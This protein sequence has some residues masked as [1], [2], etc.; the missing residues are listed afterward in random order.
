MIAAVY[1]VA[2][3]VALT[4]GQLYLHQVVHGVQPFSVPLHVVVALFEAINLLIAIW[5]IGLGLHQKQINAVHDGYR[6]KFKAGVIPPV[7]LFSSIPLSKALSLRYWAGEV[8]GTYSL[9]DH[10]YV[11]TT[12]LGFMLDVGNG[13]STF[14]PTV[15]TG[16]GMS[17]AGHPEFGWLV[18]GLTPRQLGLLVTAIHWQE[19]YGTL[20]YFSGYVW[21][22]RWLHHKTTPAQFVAM[23]LCTNIIWIVCPA[24]AMYGFYR[25]VMED[26]I[27][28]FLGA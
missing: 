25:M 17:V 24:T 1:V 18:G 2:F 5:E 7:F 4:L 8:W 20:C 13:F 21:N 6:K 12:S 11:E 15:L 28:V 22:A 16:L 23:V 10:S 14:V 26:S 19:L 9:L 3:V 27:D